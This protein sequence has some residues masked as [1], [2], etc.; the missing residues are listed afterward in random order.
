MTLS[1]PCRQEVQLPADII[2]EIYAFDPIGKSQLLAYKRRA[3]VQA[4]ILGEAEVGESEAYE[5]LVSEPGHQLFGQIIDSTLMDNGATGVCFNSKG[6]AIIDGDEVFCEKVAMK[7]MDDWKKTRGLEVADVRLLG[8]FKDSTGK[9]N[10]ELTKAIGLMKDEVVEDFPI[11]G[12]R[13]AKEYHDSIAMGPGNFLSYHSE[14][15]RLSG[16]AVERNPSAP[17]YE[18]L[19]MVSGTSIQGDGRATA[20]K[21]TEWLTGRL[22]E[23]AQIWKQ[24]RLYAQEKRQQ[25]G[26]GKSGRDDDDDSDDPAKKRKKKKKKSKGKPEAASQLDRKLEPIPAAE[27]A[28]PEAEAYMRSFSDLVERSGRRQKARVGMFTV[29]KKGNRLGNTRRNPTDWYEIGMSLRIWE[30]ASYSKI[31]SHLGGNGATSSSEQ[32]EK[33]FSSRRMNGKWPSHSSLKVVTS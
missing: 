12:T 5:W 28:S 17:N 13:A 6:V 32:G 24:E 20:P 30:T 23:R 4:S 25:K 1:T 11:A 16:V 29:V 7:D 10:L 3:K 21:F 8:D 27:V 18:G 2:G 33:S 15:L 31:S 26:K 19:D 22:K 14:W 9:R